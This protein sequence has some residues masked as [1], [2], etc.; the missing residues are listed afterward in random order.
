MSLFVNYM[1]EIEDLLIEK[2]NKKEI[3]SALRNKNIL[4]GAE[5]EMK[6]PEDQIQGGNV[7]T[8]EIERNQ[9]DALRDYN[10]WDD[11]IKQ[12][13]RD[14]NEYETETEELKGYVSELDDIYTNID[15]VDDDESFQEWI[16]SEGG[17]ESDRDEWI[18]D[19]NELRVEMQ[20]KRNKL[21]LK[22]VDTLK[23][24]LKIAASLY[25]EKDN[26]EDD[27]NYREDE[28][29]YEEVM[30]PYLLSGEYSNYIDYMDFIY[31]EMGFAE[32]I[33][34]S[35]SNGYYMAGEGDSIPYPVN[36]FE[37]F[38]P[39]E[40]D[41]EDTLNLDDAPFRN[42]EIGDYGDVSQK[43]GSTK[44]A[45]EPD[46]SV[47]GGVEIKSPPMPLPDFLKVMGKM[48]AWMK[49]NGYYTDRQTGF[50]IHMSM[51]K[52]TKDFDALKL[53]LFTDEGLI[54]NTFSDRVT[55]SY[56]NSVKYKLKTDGLLKPSDRKKIFNEK[57]L[58][59][60]VFSYKEHNDA[61]NV[62]SMADN[63]VEFRYM[64]SDYSNK[65]KDITQ[66]IGNY[67]HSMALAADP[68][69]KRKEYVHK[70]QRIFNKME[71]FGAITKLEEL[72]IQMEQQGLTNNKGYMGLAKKYQTTIKLLSKIYKID[73]QEM[74]ILSRN[75]RFMDSIIQELVD[76]KK[77]LK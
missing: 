73:K 22:D 46:S 67:A 7:N 39:E 77:K 59:M 69:Y 71:L 5:W 61:I 66:I 72:E 40:I 58:L 64:G 45:I 43:V 53:V 63:H 36:P 49:D 18:R 27:I 47:D 14:S 20:E 11:D 17:T 74:Y 1:K 50:H 62:V 10:Q 52:P 12:W 60:R 29:R 13:E 2:V 65:T 44:W 38:G 54:Y 70:L 51:K 30:T 75:N 35:V 8:A 33:V 23:K 25:S 15:V 68:E 56:V 19:H 48:F 31:N 55:S 32:D 26:L 3:D 41:Y 6:I 28:G 16:A 42:Y 24:V 34:S 57:K 21:S 9:K 76:D 4:V 37:I